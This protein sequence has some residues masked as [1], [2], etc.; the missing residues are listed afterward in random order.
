MKPFN[1]TILGCGSATPSKM[2]NPSAQLIN[3]HEKLILF[4]CAEGT[5]MQM[6]K[7]RV[8]NNRINHIF[9]SHLHGD[10]YLGLMGLLFTYHLFGRTNTLHIHAPKEMKNIIDIQLKVSNSQLCY[11]LIYHD[12][13][14]DEFHLELETKTF[15]LYTFPL[16]HSIPTWGFIIKESY[17]GLK[18]DKTFI[19]NEKPGINEI[20]KIKSGED[21]LNA[22]G[23][24][25]KNKDIT[26][27]GDAL[28][29]YAYC[30]DTLYD[31]EIIPYI[32]NTDLLYHEATFTHDFV[33]VA[34]SKF[35]STAKEAALIAEKANVKK[36]IIGHFSA[37]YEDTLPILNEAI[38]YFPETLLA[39]D[40]LKIEINW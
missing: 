30:T 16:K 20:H 3:L 27:E 17:T 7:Y 26:I 12:L 23:K 2:R 37:R 5:Q 28:R 9:I 29:S 32:E 4:D 40:G 34:K 24:L 1:I 10:H 35:H 13:I 31:E 36:L 25:F 11:P 18:I 6:R 14:P 22:E 38:T 15:S 33:D 21:Y 8:K 39:E 19:N